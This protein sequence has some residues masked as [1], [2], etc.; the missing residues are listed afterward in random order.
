MPA[1]RCHRARFRGQAVDQGFD[2]VLRAYGTGNG[3]NDSGQD[4]EMRCRPSSQIAQDKGKWPV[5]V[6]RK[7][8]H[9]TIDPVVL[10]SIFLLAD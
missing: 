9:V 7:M 1:I 10:I 8:I 3:C 4:H 5:R 2:A 6:S